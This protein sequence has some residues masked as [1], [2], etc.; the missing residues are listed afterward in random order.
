MFGASPARMP[1]EPLHESSGKCALRIGMGC[2]AQSAAIA[3]AIASICNA[4]DRPSPQ[5]HAA[6]RFVQRLPGHNVGMNIVI[7]DDYS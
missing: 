7:L 1:W 4:A 2:K 6:R 5:M 3:V